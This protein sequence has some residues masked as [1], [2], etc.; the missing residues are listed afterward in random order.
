[1][2]LDATE[3]TDRAIERVK[4]LIASDADAEGRY[5]NNTLSWPPIIRSL[6]VF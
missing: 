4:S 1:M 3:A 2:S 5:S 6:L